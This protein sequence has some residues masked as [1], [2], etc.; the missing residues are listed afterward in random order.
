[1]STDCDESLIVSRERL[2]EGLSLLMKRLPDMVGEHS[3]SMPFYM[4]AVLPG[5]RMFL[6]SADIEKALNSNEVIEAVWEA[7][8]S[9]QQE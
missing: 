3:E 8:K 2:R 1:M 6:A 4:K 5:L 9:C 7:L